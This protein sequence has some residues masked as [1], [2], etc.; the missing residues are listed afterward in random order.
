MTIENDPKAREAILKITNL[1]S[2]MTIKQRP[3]KTKCKNAHIN[4]NEL[5]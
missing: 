2:A 1:K 3:R 5:V 4:K